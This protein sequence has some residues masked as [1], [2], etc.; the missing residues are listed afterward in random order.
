MGIGFAAM[1]PESGA[2]STVMVGLAGFAAGS[3]L[4][5]LVAFT[6][7]AGPIAAQSSR[8]PAATLVPNDRMQTPE[9]PYADRAWPYQAE[10][11]PWPFE[12]AAPERVPGPK[13]PDRLSGPDGW[14]SELAPGP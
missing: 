9:T 5:G 4:M 6:R 13:R 11:F 12:S 1:R 2:M 3:L 14:T 8:V 10:P 7:Q